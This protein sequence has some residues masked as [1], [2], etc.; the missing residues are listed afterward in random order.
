MSTVHEINLYIIN[1]LDAQ[2]LKGLN[3][4][5]GLLS[6]QKNDTRNK[7]SNYNLMKADYKRYP[8]Q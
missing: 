4:E 1:F 6:V 3:W 8:N 5:F 2:F 7:Y